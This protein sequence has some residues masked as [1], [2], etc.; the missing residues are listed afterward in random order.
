MSKIRSAVVV[1]AL[2]GAAL[3]L[4]AGPAS[5]ECL[6]YEGSTNPIMSIGGPVPYTLYAPGNV[7]PDPQDCIKAVQEVIS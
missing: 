6:Y 4:T 7:D 1:A 2:A 5:A 3:T